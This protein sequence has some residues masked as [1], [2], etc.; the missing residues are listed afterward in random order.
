MNELI[1]WGAIGGLVGA[2]TIEIIT[3]IIKRR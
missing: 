1:I 2:L 3:F